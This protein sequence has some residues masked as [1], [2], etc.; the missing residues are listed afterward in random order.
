[1][2]LVKPI[3]PEPASPGYRRHSPTE[4][5]FSTIGAFM[6]LCGIEKTGCALLASPDC[7]LYKRLCL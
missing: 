4:P 3:K 5:L 7:T 2:G 6:P 1:M